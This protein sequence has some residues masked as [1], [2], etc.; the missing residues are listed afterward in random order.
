M[1]WPL[2]NSPDTPVNA[3]A[4]GAGSNYI[5]AEIDQDSVR[6]IYCDIFCQYQHGTAPA[7]QSYFEFY[8]VR[9]E[10]GGTNYE[11]GGTS[12]DPKSGLIA[13]P[14]MDFNDTSTHY[15]MVAEHVLLPINDFKLLVKSESNQ[16]CTLT[17]KLQRYNEPTS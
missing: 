16:S 6:Y 11:D 12:V 9:K 5:S 8:F 15:I 2:P 14:T 17:V 10:P 3:Q 4:I 1:P 13:S 7:A